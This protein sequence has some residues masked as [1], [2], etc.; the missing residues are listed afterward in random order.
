MHECRLRS[1]GALMTGEAK[2]IQALR[3]QTDAGGHDE[4]ELEN[5]TQELGRATGLGGRSRSFADASER[6]R[7]A[8][9]KAIK[10][11]IDEIALANPVVGRDLASTIE[12]GTLCCYRPDL[13]TT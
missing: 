9:Q 12:T 10:R 4:A 11:A 13:K 8:V 1:A 6:A 5:L 7:M 3:E 2:R